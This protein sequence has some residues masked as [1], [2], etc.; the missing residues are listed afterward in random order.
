MKMNMVQFQAFEAMQKAMAA[1]A[2]SFTDEEL[3]EVMM[4]A[5]C[6]GTTVF[7]LATELKT[8]LESKRE[9]MLDQVFGSKPGSEEREPPCSICECEG[10]EEDTGFI[11]TPCAEKFGGN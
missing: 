11:C 5:N 3:E 4:Q 9:D 2:S 10:L 7:E 8:F 6:K 1:M